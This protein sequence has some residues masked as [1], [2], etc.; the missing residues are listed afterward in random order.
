MFFVAGFGG[1]PKQYRVYSKVTN[2]VTP[3]GL[4]LI[5]HKESETD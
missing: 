1:R 4:R 5:G 3:K 2:C